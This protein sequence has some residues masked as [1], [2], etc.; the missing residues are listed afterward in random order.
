MSTDPTLFGA[1]E[2]DAVLSDCG[3]YRYHLLRRWGPGKACVFAMLNPSTADATVDDPT[4]RRCIGFAKREGCDALVVVNAYGLRATD[5][6]LLWTASD[7]VGPLNDRFVRL[8]L[9]CAHRDDAPIIAAWGAHARPDRVL[10]MSR[11]T[12][13]RWSCLGITKSG[14]PRH[15]LYV[16]ADAPLIGWPT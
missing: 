12:Q 4:I 14:A 9:D 15:P 11:L 7:P 10:Q 16:R 5:P 1:V 13:V 2:S 3:M 6:K 8:A